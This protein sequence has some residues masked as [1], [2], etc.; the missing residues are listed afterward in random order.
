LAA[1]EAAFFVSRC[2]WC[3]SRRYRRC[4]IGR[5]QIV[6]TGDADQRE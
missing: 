1:V 6:F 5:I 3:R 4:K 2:M